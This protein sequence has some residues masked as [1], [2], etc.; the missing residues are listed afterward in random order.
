M[1]A[2]KLSVRIGADRRLVVE[3]PD[4]VQEG[5]AELILLT[6]ERQQTVA[7]GED[8]VDAHIERLLARPRGRPAAQID[9]EIEAER[10][11]WD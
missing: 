11:S 9:R 6:S 10:A 2:I 3:L 4:D 5:P 1:R 8:P 7:D